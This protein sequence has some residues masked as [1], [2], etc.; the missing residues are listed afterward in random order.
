MKGRRRDGRRERE[1][2][3]DG[4]AE[5][6]QRFVGTAKNGQR[7]LLTKLV[8]GTEKKVDSLP[9]PPPSSPPLLYFEFM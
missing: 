3:P 9:S 2:A 5:V 4:A 8:D 6:P 1:R 7:A